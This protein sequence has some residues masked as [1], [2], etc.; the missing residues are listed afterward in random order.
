MQISKEWLHVCTELIFSR[1]S[2]LQAF[3]QNITAEYLKV[4]TGECNDPFRLP[5]PPS[6]SFE[7]HLSQTSFS[8]RCPS[9]FPIHNI[10]KQ[11]AGRESTLQA[12]RVPRVADLASI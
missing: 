4:Y 3:H 9:H 10:E 7:P 1:L 2:E 5:S 8:R 11:P 12:L 6:P